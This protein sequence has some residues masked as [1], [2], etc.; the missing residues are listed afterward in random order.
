MWCPCWYSL[1]R[2]YLACVSI[3]TGGQCTRRSCSGRDETPRATAADRFVWGSVRTQRRGSPLCPRS[4]PRRVSSVSSSAIRLSP[5]NRIL[6]V[7]FDGA[8]ALAAF[9]ILVNLY[10]NPDN[11]SSST[12]SSFKIAKFFIKMLVIHFRK[13]IQRSNRIIN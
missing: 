2:K 12:D 11:D 8:L 7:T 5:N 13:Y 9:P 6:E 1:E 3:C 10:E 4:G